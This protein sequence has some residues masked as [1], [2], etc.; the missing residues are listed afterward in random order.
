MLLTKKVGFQ[1]CCTAGFGLCI[2]ACLSDWA[3]NVCM[4]T[5]LA[6]YPARV[7]TAAIL[8]RIFT[9]LKYAVMIAMIALIIYMLIKDKKRI[10]G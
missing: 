2:C 9:A 7:M 1:R 4:I 10:S 5:V 3:E 8:A 6:N